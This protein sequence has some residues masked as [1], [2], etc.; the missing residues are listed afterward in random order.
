MFK[1]ILFLTF[2]LVSF[3]VLM[4]TEA[5]P[6]AGER[7][8]T[9]QV[10]AIP[11]NLKPAFSADLIRGDA[12]GDAEINGGDIVY[13]IVYFFRGGPPPPSL[14]QGDANGDGVIDPQDMV[15]LINYLFLG[16]TPPPP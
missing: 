12:N 4:H 7:A 8:I 5:I 15:Y 10:R 2:I 16:G 14:E 11:F 6:K 3:S 1:R 13:L 9:N